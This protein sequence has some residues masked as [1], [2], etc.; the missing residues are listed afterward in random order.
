MLDDWGQHQS[1][2]HTSARS[3][4]SGSNVGD[5]LAPTKYSSSNMERKMSDRSCSISNEL[6]L[7]G[8]F[9]D[10]I[11][12]VDGVE[13]KAHKLILSCCSIY[14]RSVLETQG[15]GDKQYSLIEVTLPQHV[16]STS[17]C[18]EPLIKQFPVV[19]RPP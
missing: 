8:R 5:S 3:T 4:A 19:L 11:I 2:P 6:R 16:S 12:S 14:F 1:A 18:T 7:E 17:I 10:V 13:F 15:N 9:C